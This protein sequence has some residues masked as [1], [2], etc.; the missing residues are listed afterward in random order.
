MARKKQLSLE[1]RQFIALLRKE[2][3]SMRD[4]TKKLKLSYHAVNYSLRRVRQTGSN[5]DRKRSGRPRCTTVQEDKYLRVCSLR[6]RCL[7]GCQLTASN[8]SVSIN[9]QEEISLYIQSFVTPDPKFNLEAEFDHIRRPL[10]LPGLPANCE[11]SCGEGI[12]GC[13]RRRRR[14]RGRRA[15]V[16]VRLK[17]LLGDPTIP[18]GVCIL[19]E[20]EGLE[21]CH[22]APRSWDDLYVWL[23]VV[24]LAG[25][26]PGC[27]AGSYRCTQ[28]KDFK[29]V[30]CY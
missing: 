13:R 22:I 24:D 20:A 8:T 3:Y 15:G 2:G 30:K 21:R 19:G 25:G 28:S 7:T 26:A 10:V 29:S 17:R 27:W 5:K 4:I 9:C 14:K 11:F 16:P 1:T 6:E 23:R 12:A 18:A